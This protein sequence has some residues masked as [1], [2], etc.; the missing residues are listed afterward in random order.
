MKKNDQTK[1]RY[2]P[3]LKNE[4]DK[5]LLQNPLVKAGKMFGYP[6]YYVNGK[7]AICHYDNGLALKLPAEAVLKL[8]SYTI[9]SEPFC[10]M[11]KKMGDNWIILFPKTPEEIK[12]YEEILIDS[13]LFLHH[14]TK[15]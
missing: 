11:G 2:W 13:V 7:L 4:V 9:L 1:L 14:S 15:K 8:K 5:I 10:P 3:D 12:E 6:A